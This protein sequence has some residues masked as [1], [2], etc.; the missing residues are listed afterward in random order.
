[1]NLETL[2]R[3]SVADH[4]SGPVPEPD[5]VALTRRHLARSRPRAGMLVPAVALAAAGAIAVGSIL[6]RPLIAD[7]QAPLAVQPTDGLHVYLAAATQVAMDGTLH[8]R[9]HGGPKGMAVATPEGVVYL[10]DDRRPYLMTPEGEETPIGDLVSDD[11]D[12]SP[13]LAADVASST[14][15]WTSRADGR[16]TVH[17]YDLVDGKE[18]RRR[19]PL[20]KSDTDTPASDGVIHGVATGIVVIA[21]RS[22]AGTEYRIWN[23][24]TDAGFFEPEVTGDL[25]VSGVAGR[26]ILT[27][28]PGELGRGGPGGGLDGWAVV[29]LEGE[30]DGEQQYLSPDGRLR[31]IAGNSVH[32]DGRPG[33]PVVVEDVATKQRTELRIEE[34]RRDI[35]QV[36]FDTDGSPMVLTKLEGR[37]G[38]T[39]YDCE[40]PEEGEESLPCHVQATEI[41]QASFPGEGT[42]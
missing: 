10:G 39:L 19:I 33:D 26:T 29:R 27:Y 42:F 8:T 22:D 35:P 31:L 5:M 4:T 41:R 17:V 38:W 24:M 3:D 11:P 13:S 23:T 28:G 18:Q 6:V 1:M 14:V 20:Q 32:Q 7:D 16:T 25:M 37:K 2:V 9:T 36:S 21:M 15:A 30:H 12:W 34:D 40:V